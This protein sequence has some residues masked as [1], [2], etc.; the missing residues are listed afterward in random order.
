[1][2]RGGHDGPLTI[3]GAERHRPY[4]RPPLSKQVLTRKV[5]PEATALHEAED[6]DAE[7]VLG[8][9]ATSLDAEKKVI[10]LS[11]AEELPYDLLVIATGA[12]PRRLPG[13]EP[14]PGLHYLRTLDDAVR[15]RDDMSA[16]SKVTVIGAG[17]IG[18]EVA[19]SA[20][21]LG[22]DVTV[23]EALPIPLERAV[24]DR[25]GNEIADLHR[26]RGIDLRTD[27]MVEGPAGDGRT[28]GV[29]LSG[30]EVVEADV[31]V[32]GIG[33]APETGWLEDSKVDLNDGVLC[34]SRL[35][36]LSGG[37]PL[38][39][40]VAAG[41]VA[42]WPH[43]GWSRLARVEH[44]TNAVEQGE[45][46]ARTLLE[47]DSA[48]PFAPVPYFWSDQHGMKIQFVG[49]TATGDEV[50]LIEG[51]FEEERFLVAYGRAGRLVAALGIRRPARVMAMQR[52]IGEN[53]A[54]PPAPA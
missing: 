9:G 32:V 20:S 53:A 21:E 33:V 22:L 31:I 34:D 17:F 44:W 8:T 50:S 43:P 37:R 40:V 15:L 2:R 41:D 52:L 5:Q 35:R 47:G 26:R 12:H 18:L 25:M 3:V 27:V 36:V 23:L 46:A 11:G 49:E 24:G 16:A 6:L 7:W 54:F 10:L 29:R 48:P 38:P 28:E 4:D 19:A 51:S 1:L 13:F 39:G 30:G 14:G 42:R 45:A